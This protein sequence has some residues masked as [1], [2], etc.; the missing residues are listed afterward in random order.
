MTV[1]REQV[2]IFAFLK[3]PQDLGTNC[4]SECDEIYTQAVLR[5]YESGVTWTFRI[6]EDENSIPHS[7]AELRDVGKVSE[8]LDEESLT[9][10]QRA[11]WVVEALRD[12]RLTA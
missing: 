3:Q 9:V 7:E 2:V 10:G 6:V 12:P 4:M 1:T 8:I 5:L 11:E